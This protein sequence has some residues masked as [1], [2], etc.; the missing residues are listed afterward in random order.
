MIRG[1]CLC[2]AVRYE[3]AGSFVESHHCHCGMCRKQHGAAFA[4]YAACKGREL[5][6]EGEDQVA[7]FASTPAVKRKFC[8][9]CGSSLF[10]THEAAPNLVWVAAGTMDDR[11]AAEA[12]LPAPDANSFAGSKAR[13]W[14]IH[15]ALPAHEGQRP[16]LTGG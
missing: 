13:W 1:S 10:F 16:E 2:G 8:R 3:I 5:K 11:D 9:T 4:T 14:T 15:D 7:E 6:I 12:D